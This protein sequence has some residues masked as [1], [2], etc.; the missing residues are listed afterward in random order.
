M[1]KIYVA[2]SWR[3]AIQQNVVSAL[4][5]TGHEV[6][7]FKNPSDGYNGFHWSDI[8]AKWKN[9]SPGEY[10]ANLNNPIAER[11]FKSDFDAMNWAD[12]FVLVQPCGRS[13]HLELGWAC[14]AGKRTCILLEDG[15]PE[16]MVKMVDFIAIDLNEVIQWL[17]I[18]NHDMQIEKA[19]CKK[20]GGTVVCTCGTG[21]CG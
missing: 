5:V 19:G 16:L 7:D 18:I 3:N 15:E 20:C 8:D 4:R 13:A 21:R 17:T 12:T 2:S 6:Y 11:G 1:S 14:G 10:R 9:W